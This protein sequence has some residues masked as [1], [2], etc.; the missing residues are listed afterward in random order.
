MAAFASRQGA[1]QTR[2]GL[3]I[4]ENLYKPTLVSEKAAVPTLIPVKS[5]NYRSTL[6]TLS[7]LC[8]TCS[9]LR[10][11]AQ[12]LMYREFAFGYGEPEHPKRLGGW[13]GRLISLAINTSTDRL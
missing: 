9:W 7:Q 3:M 1:C 4:I 10:K 2:F 6:D 12:P 11:L 13:R 8:L 5:K